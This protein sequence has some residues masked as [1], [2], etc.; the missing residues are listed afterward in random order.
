[1]TPIRY[2]QNA[3]IP[4][5][6]LLPATMDTDRAVAMMIAIALQESDLE[7][8]RQFPTGPG[9][10]YPQFELGLEEHG[11]PTGGLSLLLRHKAAGPLC[12]RVVND[13]DYGG[14]TPTELHA[15]LEHN[16]I[17]AAAMT[18]LLLFTYPGPLPGSTESDEG[19]RQ[20]MWCWRP[21]RPRPN[22]W[23]R[24]FAMAWESGL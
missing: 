5:L 3:V 14:A 17:L 18:R 12:A 4:A 7:H 24:C 15:A 10:G 20:Y 23:G 16:D 21:S 9:R 6:R 11:K 19:W 2:Y 8:R 22:H 13:L 1:M